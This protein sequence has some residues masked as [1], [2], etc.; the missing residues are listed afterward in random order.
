MAVFVALDSF[1]VVYFAMV[2]FGFILEQPPLL[3][4]IFGDS[5]E[6]AEKSGVSK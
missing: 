1:G 4:L 6:Q 2:T 5:V 3:P